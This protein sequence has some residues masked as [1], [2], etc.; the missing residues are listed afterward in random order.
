VR[1]GRRDEAEALAAAF[2]S[3]HARSPY[4]K[5]IRALV[6]SPKSATAQP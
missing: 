1:A 6:A 3:S 2:L 4:A 5:R